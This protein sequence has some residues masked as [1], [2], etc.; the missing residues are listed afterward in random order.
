M[1]VCPIPVKDVK[2]L[3]AAA[4]TNAGKITI[5]QCPG[6]AAAQRLAGELFKQNA[7]VDLLHIPYKSTPEVLAAL[8]SKSVDVV[9]DAV[10]VLL[11]QVQAGSVR[12]L[13]VTG[14]DRWPTTPDIPP[15]WNTAWYR[16]YDVYSWNQMYRPK[17]I[18][19]AVIAK[20]NKPVNEMIEEPAVHE[21]LVKIGL[22]V[23]GSKTDTSP[24]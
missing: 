17:G 8:H 23:Q 24:R 10:T 21:R 5:R 2:W 18:P 4:K 19:P 12:A 6:F 3:V 7:G 11:G 9:I 20:L 22:V 16:N 14:K 13:A 15:S 1:V